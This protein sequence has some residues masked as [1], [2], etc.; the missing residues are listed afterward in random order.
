[1]LVWGVLFGCLEVFGRVS[2]NDGTDAVGVVLVL[3]LLAATRMR[4]GNRLRELWSGP[5]G[6]RWTERLACL[7]LTLGLDLRREPP[8]RARLPRPYVW[9]V[10]MTACAGIAMWAARDV[11]PSQAREAVRGVSGLVYLLC[12]TALWCSL[13]SGTL[14]TFGG[15]VHYIR[16]RTPS[17]TRR[18]GE[19]TSAMLLGWGV[20]FVLVPCAVYFPRVTSVY[21]TLGTFGLMALAFGF[22][23]RRPLLLIWRVSS[24][25]E[26]P[27]RMNASLVS[28]GMGACAC[29]LAVLLSVVSGGDRIDAAGAPETTLTALLGLAFGW[30]A[31]A[32]CAVVFVGESISLVRHRILDPA[33]PAPTRVAVHGARDAS[34][35]RAA[36]WALRRAGMTVTFDPRRH[37]PSTVPVQLAE[38]SEPSD[39]FAPVQ[40]PLHVRLD[41]LDDPRLH[42]AL[43]RRDRV[44][45]RRELRRRL[46]S[47]F[48]ELNA[49]RYEHGTGTWIAPHLWFVARLSRDTDEGGAV[50]TGRSFARAISRAA[51]SHLFEV[52]D[53]LEIDLIFLEDGVGFRR[54][55]R[56]LSQIFEYYDMFGARRLEDE[57]HFSGL[58]G[59]RV[60]IHDCFQ[61]ESERKTAYPEPDYEELGRARVLHVFRDRGGLDEE[62]PVDLDRTPEWLPSLLPVGV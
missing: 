30:C 20:L 8:V 21:V 35:R 47:L 28:V 17:I 15:C 32:S 40:W 13:A 42:E 46:E 31:A 62:A 12:V 58:P 54:F 1:M 44:V 48:R 26:P 41:A 16:E 25:E 57:R 2:P 51:R 52:L 29:S 34:D 22:P 7:D 43:R 24:S 19:D 18:F 10:G 38:R 36:R 59:V 49:K 4:M 3:A 56:V 23:S 39:P 45:R 33:R 27:A 6:R 55:A 14:V 60:L 53:A 50:P 11:F 5:F 9:V 61:E 37:R